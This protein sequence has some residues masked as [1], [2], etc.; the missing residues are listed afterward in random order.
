MKYHLVNWCP[1]AELSSGKFIQSDN[2]FIESV[3]DCRSAGL[4]PF[5]YGLLP[6]KDGQESSVVFEISERIT[7]RLE[8]TLKYCNAVTGEGVRLYYDHLSSA[9]LKADYIFS[10]SASEDTGGET[11]YFHVILS[12]DPF[13]RVATGIPDV[14]ETPLHYP[15][16]VPCYR[17]FLLPAEDESVR[18]PG[19]HYLIVGRIRRARG[20]CELDTD[21]IPPATSMASHTRLSRYHNQFISLMNAIEDNSVRMIQKINNT[22][23]SNSISANLQALCHSTLSDISRIYFSYTSSGLFWMPIEVVSCFSTLAHHLFVAL[24]CLNKKEK[25]Q[26][27]NYF[28]EWDDLKPGDLESLLKEITDIHYDHSSISKVMFQISNFLMILSGLWA[29][30]ASLELIGQHKESIIISERETAPILPKKKRWFD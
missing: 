7:N 24:Q 23:D 30:M 4:N 26:L 22:P 19:G 29:K 27:L 14:R 5:N 17:L 12:V 21:F 28:Y 6:C 16:I 8:V 1:G 11:C 13:S 9:P 10:E 25:E 3:N 18:E 15:D 20:R 2:Y